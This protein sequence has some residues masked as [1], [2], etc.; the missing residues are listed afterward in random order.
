MYY[1]SQQQVYVP[2]EWNI[3][4]AFTILGIGCNGRRNFNQRTGTAAFSR[5]EY[6]G[7]RFAVLTL[8]Q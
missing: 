8:K 3:D 1:F 5:G 7:L 6:F 2:Y 4:R